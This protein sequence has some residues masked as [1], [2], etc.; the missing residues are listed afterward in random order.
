MH[1]AYELEVLVANTSSN[2]AKKKIV[3]GAGIIKHVSIV[4]PAGCGA[5]V[6]C[7]FMDNAVQLLPTNLE[8]YY[9]EDSY[10]IEADCYIDMKDFSNE[11][12]FVAW[13]VGT[14]YD[15]TLHIL[16]D[17]QGVNEPTP[18]QSIL[19]LAEAIN[20]LVQLMRSWF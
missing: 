16:L 9:A 19:V 15:H 13:D 17:V 10:V 18:N 20:N 1:Y 7:Y 5:L 14:L 6:R 11:F 3:L 8:S 12:W 4:F 2:P